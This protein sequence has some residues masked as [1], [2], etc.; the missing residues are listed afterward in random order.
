MKSIFWNEFNIFAIVSLVFDMGPKSG[1]NQ[2]YVEIIENDESIAPTRFC[3]TDNPAPY[4]AKSNQL[5]VH[6]KNQARFHGTGWVI[7]FMALHENS[8]MDVL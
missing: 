6:F 5:K 1:C 7:H 8:D 3:G 4:K 2:T